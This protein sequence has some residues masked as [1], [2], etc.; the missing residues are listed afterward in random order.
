MRPEWSLCLGLLLMMLCLLATPGPARAKGAAKP[1]A[2]PAV[3]LVPNVAYGSNKQLLNLYEPQKGRERRKTAILFIHGGGWQGGARSE[4]A[5][6]A[7]SMA[8]KG[9]VSASMD[10]R[11]TPK[12]RFPQPL[13]DVREA[14]A[15]M[16][17]NAGQYDFDPDRLVLVGYSAGGHLALMAGLEPQN[18][19]AAVISLA[20]PTQ[21]YDGAGTWDPDLDHLIDDLLKGAKPQ[22][23]SPVDFVHA[24]APP[25][26]LMQGEL[27]GLVHK[28]Q[29]LALAKAL[30]AKKSP[31]R[32]IWYPEVGHE[33]IY[34]NSKRIKQTWADFEAFI[35]RVEAKG[36]KAKP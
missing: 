32:V 5:P 22:S 19:V 9:Y 23:A 7:Q 20:G 28:Q 31:V 36:R 27:D 12:A 25:I 15:W 21:L 14:I 24:D 30:R 8:A 18:N 4:F 10:Y 13:E 34:P 16:K 11:L 35:E 26:L 3:H 17:A 6:W 33:I 2:R 1:A 29:P